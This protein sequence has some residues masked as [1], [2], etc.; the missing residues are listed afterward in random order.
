MEPR[1]IRDASDAR[2]CLAAVDASG[3]SRLAW[4]KANGVNAR[5]LNAWHVNLT[6]T[7]RRG[8][9]RG[10]VRLVE[11]VPS[12]TPPAVAYR[13]RCGRFEVDIDGAIDEERLTRLLR[14]MAA[15]C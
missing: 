11:L 4:A 15:A 13:V 10:P 7:S 6:Q 14:V 1:K 9:S 12:G 5:S 3:S 2:A 8:R